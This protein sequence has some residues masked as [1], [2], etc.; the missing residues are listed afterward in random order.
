MVAGI[1]HAASEAQTTFVGGRRAVGYRS[2]HRMKHPS[3]WQ[4]C[5]HAAAAARRSVREKSLPLKRRGRSE[6]RANA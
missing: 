3:S 1:V 6:R 4:G 2:D 5:N